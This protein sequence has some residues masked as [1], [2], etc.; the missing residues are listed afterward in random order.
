[1]S[2]QRSTSG[3]ANPFRDPPVIVTAIVPMPTWSAI[4]V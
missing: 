4:A 3:R 1:M 2:R